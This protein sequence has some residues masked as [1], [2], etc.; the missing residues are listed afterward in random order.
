MPYRPSISDLR[1]AI[2]RFCDLRLAFS[3]TGP[4][5]RAFNEMATLSGAGVVS[6]W[7]TTTVNER[8]V[9][10]Y[11][12]YTLTPALDYCFFVAAFAAGMACYPV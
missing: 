4:E 9:S 8:S 7:N 11:T 6:G 2:L 1:P 10:C 12:C 3:L 5:T